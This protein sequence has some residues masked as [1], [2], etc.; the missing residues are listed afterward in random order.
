MSVK[1]L[2]MYCENAILF[3]LKN[4]FQALQYDKQGHQLISYA[5]QRGMSTRLK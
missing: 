1:R 5:G 4:L 2:L 3:Q